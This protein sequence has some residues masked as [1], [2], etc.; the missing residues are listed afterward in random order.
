MQTLIK[1]TVSQD[2]MLQVFFMNHLPPSPWKWHEGYF[3]FIRKFAEIFASQGVPPVSLTPVAIA[4][5]VNYA[6]V[7]FAAGVNYTG[8]K[9]VTGTA[10]VVDAGGK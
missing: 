3:D 4:T 7:K 2:F 10:V 6:G 8:G 5:G 1:G 9:F